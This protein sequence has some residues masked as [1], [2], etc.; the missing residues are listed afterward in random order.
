MA[1]YLVSDIGG[2][3]CRAGL[4][5]KKEGVCRLLR[6]REVQT[7]SIS[8][9]SALASLLRSL[10]PEDATPK[11][12]A[13][14]FAGPVIDGEARLTNAPLTLSSSALRE[15]IG[16]SS[17]PVFLLNDFAAQAYAT[18][19]AAGDDLLTVRDGCKISGVRG[20]IGAGTGLG[21]VAMITDRGEPLVLSSEGGHIPFPFE[22]GEEERLAGLIRDECGG[23]MP[24]A[25]DVLSGRG[26]ERIHMCLTDER[27]GAREIGARFL[28]GESPTTTLFAR[29][30]ARF[31]HMW[32]LATCCYEGLWIGGGIAAKNPHV[33]MCRAFR[34]ELARLQGETSFSRIPLYLL[35]STD[36]GLL[37]AGTFLASREN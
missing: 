23:R 3:H 4:C 19:S 32:M 12:L 18:L 28:Q 29:W 16:F 1:L 33:V 22:G 37:G 10:L 21:A 2:T 13:V 8:G 27:R 36:A 35:R 24:E 15:A 17:L 26:L 34:E 5:E 20:C 6:K 14:A 30:Y 9:I 25:E 7:R 11:G 31:A